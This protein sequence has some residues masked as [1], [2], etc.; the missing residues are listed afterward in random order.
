MLTLAS[1][2]LP[3]L[4]GLCNGGRV[5]SAASGMAVSQTPAV[6]LATAAAV[7]VPAIV[8][9]LP[10]LAALPYSRR[11]A[12]GLAA[13]AA[14]YL[15]LQL[16]HTLATALGRRPRW[17]PWTL[18]AQVALT[19]LPVAVC[20]GWVDGPSP[21][22]AGVLLMALRPPWA[23]AAVGAVA[24]AEFPLALSV[25]G[26]ARS[27]AIWAVDVLWLGSALFGFSRLAALFRE[28]QETNGDVARLSVDRERARIARDLHDLLGRSLTGI[29]LNGELAAKLTRDDPARAEAELAG[30]TAMAREALVDLDTVARGPYALPFHAEVEQSVA[31]L[32]RAGIRCSVRVADGRL[33]G[34]AEGV[35]AWA[36]REGVTNALRHSRATTCAIALRPDHGNHRLDVVNDGA[37]TEPAAAGHTPGSGLAALEERVAEVGGRSWV[38]RTGAQFRLVVEVPA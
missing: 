21:L 20:P 14:T 19:Y 24:I 23:L 16:H 8:I 13:V 9:A 1:G 28:L 3:V 33:T 6:R 18:G 15:A 12:V 10:S 29:A 35:L 17:L 38:E 36:V 7:A 25:T 4:W 30:L 26:D 32:E 27:A 34:P 22:L 31:L 37:G 11:D 2:A 5:T